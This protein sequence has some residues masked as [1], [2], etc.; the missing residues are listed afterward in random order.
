MLPLCTLSHLSPLSVFH[1]L[2]AITEARLRICGVS[3]SLF[4]GLSAAN[5]IPVI[6][7]TTLAATQYW[8]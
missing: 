8:S 2:L 3:E 1:V 7:D 4:P 6:P 5:L